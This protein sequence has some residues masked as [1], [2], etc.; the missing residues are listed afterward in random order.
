MITL[1]RIIF[2]HHRSS[3]WIGICT[4]VAIDIN[5]IIILEALF[6]CCNYVDR[7]SQNSSTAL[8]SLRPLHVHAITPSTPPMRH[9]PFFSNFALSNFKLALSLFSLLTFHFFILFN[10]S[11]GWGEMGGGVEGGRGGGFFYFCITFPIGT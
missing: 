3:N 8:L 1:T 5:I 6:E 7:I 2:M 10:T 11:G 9:N 4:V